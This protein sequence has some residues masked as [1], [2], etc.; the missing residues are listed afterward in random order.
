MEEAK[1]KI[2]DENEI[3]HLRCEEPTFLLLALPNGIAYPGL[4]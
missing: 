2:L 3:F 4:Y 1:W